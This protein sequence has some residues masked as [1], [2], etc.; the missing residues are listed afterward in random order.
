[1]QTPEHVSVRSVSFRA[2]RILLGN[3]SKQWFVEIGGISCI[4]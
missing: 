4:Y 1:L 3:W 2:E